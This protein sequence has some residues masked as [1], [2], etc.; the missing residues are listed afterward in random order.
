MLSHFITLLFGVAL[1]MV[2]VVLSAYGVPQIGSDGHWQNVVPWLV[3]IG[4][5]SLAIG[6]R[7]VW[8]V[9]YRHAGQS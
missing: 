4:V 8:L 7:M 6:M 1:G 9:A 2:L 5:T 3:V